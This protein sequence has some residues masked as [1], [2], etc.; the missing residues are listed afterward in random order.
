MSGSAALWC[1][2]HSTPMQSSIIV[3]VSLY[4]HHR[5]AVFQLPEAQAISLPPS[6]APTIGL[7][8]NEISRQY[9]KL[10]QQLIN[11]HLR[12]EGADASQRIL[13]RDSSLHLEDHIAVHLIPPLGSK[14]W[15]RKAVAPAKLPES[16]EEVSQNDLS[17]PFYTTFTD[18]VPQSDWPAPLPPTSVLLSTGGASVSLCKRKLILGESKCFWAIPGAVL[19]GPAPLDPSV[20]HTIVAAGV[21]TIVDLRA[22][23][24]GP[25]Y[26]TTLRVVQAELLEK[27]FQEEARSSSFTPEQVNA[28]QLQHYR[29][30]HSNRGGAPTPSQSARDRAVPEE[31]SIAIFASKLLTR[32]Q[33][34]TRFY[35]HCSGANFRSAML[36]RCV[37]ALQLASC[38]NMR[39]PSRTNA[40]FK[41]VH[42]RVSRPS[43]PLPSP[44]LPSLQPTLTP[45]P[46]PTPRTTPRSSLRARRLGTFFAWQFADRDGV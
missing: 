32:A 13:T 6:Q 39:R 46:L 14:G 5:R 29:I 12:R 22:D 44:L 24:E 23:G 8:L 40:L 21:T 17:R 34:G 10:S 18:F 36:G 31:S 37:H 25:S 16:T 2:A 35:I 30:P 38:I 27:R 20:L 3:R 19:C 28:V 43:H 4:P 45:L 33:Q 26:E 9:P 42:T 1:I 41:S 7:L 11:C 15:E